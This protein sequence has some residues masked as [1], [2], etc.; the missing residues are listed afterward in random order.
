MSNVEYENCITMIFQLG[1]VVISKIYVFKFN[2]LKSFEIVLVHIR[3]F[4]YMTKHL[5]IEN[6]R[7]P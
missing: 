7:E 6:A 2:K 3:F 4:I 1:P 5:Y